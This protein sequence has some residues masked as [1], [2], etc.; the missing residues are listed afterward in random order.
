MILGKR[1][2]ISWGTQPAR[3]FK[4]KNMASL[5]QITLLG[6][7]GKDP[8]VRRLESGSVFAN[9][10]L[11]TTEF[12][13]DKSGERKET[14]QWHNLSCWGNTAEIAEK[15]VHKGDLLLVSGKLV[16]DQYE[17][18]GVRHTI[19]KIKVDQL[20]LLGGKKSERPA[21]DAVTPP[22]NEQNDEP[23]GDDLPFIITILLAVGG[24]LPYLF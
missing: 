18:D 22:I 6:R 13:K 16:Y 9:L 21:N 15:Y 3:V 1:A 12:W 4:N 11:A 17:K 8:E 24:I 19:A 20:V 7:I 5:N 23:V 14:T 2:G 10:T